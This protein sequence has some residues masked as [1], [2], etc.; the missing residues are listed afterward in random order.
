[1]ISELGF[2]QSFNRDPEE[3]LK[4]IELQRALALVDFS[5]IS[6]GKRV[7]SRRHALPSGPS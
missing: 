5:A 6:G 2:I 1:M 3:M 4:T 7:S